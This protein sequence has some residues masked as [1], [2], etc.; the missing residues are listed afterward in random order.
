MKLGLSAA[1][2]YFCG[3]SNHDIVL[4]HRISTPRVYKAAYGVM[5]ASNLCP[6]LI[7]E[8]L[9][10][11][12]QCL[13]Y[14]VFKHMS[15]AQFDKCVMTVDGMLVWT[16]QPNAPDCKDVDIGQCSFHCYQK[17]KFGMLLLAGYY[18]AWLTVIAPGYTIFRDN[19]FVESNY[20]K[21]ISK[22]EDAYNFYFSQLHITIQQAFGIFYA[23]EPHFQSIL[24]LKRCPE[25]EQVFRQ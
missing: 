3:R 4:T 2:W 15:A 23:A 11:T 14:E 20:G 25:I 18:T 21:N 10:H 5:N 12:E 22:N 16:T 8:F 24:I 19:A 13:I 9:S 1:I 17:D 7:A 6:Q